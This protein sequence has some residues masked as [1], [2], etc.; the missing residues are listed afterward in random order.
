MAA[1]T[2]K[3][4]GVDVRGRPRRVKHGHD[5]VSG[6]I[7]GHERWYEAQDLVVRIGLGAR[8]RRQ[9]MFSC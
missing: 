9:D 1:R 6:W 2:L 4:K 7:I 3:K 5:G 8:E